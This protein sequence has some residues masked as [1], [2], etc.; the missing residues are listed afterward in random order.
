MGRFYFLA[1]FEDYF[2]LYFTD[3]FI[4]APPSQPS[5]KGAGVVL[6]FPL[7]ENERG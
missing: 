5:P 3:I 2:M 7:G 4:L 1:L 6:P